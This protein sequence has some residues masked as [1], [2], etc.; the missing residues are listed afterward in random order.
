[1]KNMNIPT[2]TKETKRLEAI[3]NKKVSVLQND[4][5]LPFFLPKKDIPM[6]FIALHQ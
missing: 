2:K 1:M 5:M 3:K 6:T 4:L